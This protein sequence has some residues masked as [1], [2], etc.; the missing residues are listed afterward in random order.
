M[1]YARLLGCLL[2]LCVV[3]WGQTRAYTGAVLVNP[4]AEPILDAVIV[5]E[6]DRITHAGPAGSLPVPAGATVVDMRGKY[7][8]P[9]LVDAHVHFFQS[10]GLYT[11]PDG[12]DLRTRVPYDREQ[13][14]IRRDL[15]DTF[16][17]YLRS[18]ITAVAD[19][20][21]PAWNFQIREQAT[22]APL[23][24]RVAV[25]GPLLADRSP[26]ELKSDDLSIVKV[27][28]PE[29]ARAM[30]RQQAER[31][32]E[33]IKLWYTSN[34]LRP[35]A[36]IAQ[37]AIAEAHARGLRVA[38]HTQA[39]EVAR[40]VVEQG[41]SVLVHGVLDREVDQAFIDLL[42]RQQVTYIP[43]L[44]VRQRWT[45]TLSQRLDFTPLEMRLGNPF[46][47]GSLSDLQHIPE[48][49]LPARYVALRAQLKD[50]AARQQF[51]AQMAPSP[52]EMRNLKRLVEAGVRV[53]TGSD[54]GNPGTLHGPSLFRELELMES[55]GVSLRELLAAATVNGARVMGREKE[56]G[57]VLPGKL[58]DFVALN[59]DPLQRLANWSDPFLIVKGGVAHRPEEILSETPE[60]L[61]QRQVNAYNARD[62][63]GFLAT[64]APDAQLL[65]LTDG[66]VRAQGVA[67]MRPVYSRL[68][69]VPNLHCQIVNRIRQ[70]SFVIDQERVRAGQQEAGATAIY[71]VRDG[72]IRRVWFAQ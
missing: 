44:L 30:V 57:S 10:G 16:A 5:T 46:V 40:F 18:G 1:A 25:A 70:G 45:R 54:A 28:N 6:G 65:N 49:D 17:R 20:G 43:T 66:K 4:G 41:A 36:A 53:A 31:R 12:L 11:R 48:A 72:A 35:F 19:L 26:E 7:V 69:Q 27:T 56:L 2:P 61:V 37:A 64:Y 29:Q 47:I 51:E 59:G 50:P 21:G 68:F 9:G 62:L 58:A 42:K 22:K 13:A 38:V 52:V 34:H 23:A 71:E 8:I 63:E 33:L 15:P 67:A 32:P 14:A 60:M 39:L 3:A 24:P 55:S